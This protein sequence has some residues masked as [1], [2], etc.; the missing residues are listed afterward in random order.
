MEG[1]TSTKRLDQE[2]SDIRDAGAAVCTFVSV[3]TRMAA[4]RLAFPS[5]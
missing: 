1:K 5:V 4:D 2:R 3:A